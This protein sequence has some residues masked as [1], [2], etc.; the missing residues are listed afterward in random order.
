[1]RLAICA[2]VMAVIAISTYWLG[3]QQ[4]E[5]PQNVYQA[6]PTDPNLVQWRQNWREAGDSIVTANIVGATG[7]Q[8]YV[9]L[10]YIYSGSHGDEV[11]VCGNVTRNGRGGNWSCS[12]TLIRKGRGFT[13]LRLG[14]STQARATECSDAIVI[15][16][17]DATGATFFKQTVPYRKTWIKGEGGLY[18]KFREY[19]SLCPQPNDI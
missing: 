1:M 2:V 12:P 6:L 19:L 7:N 14:M 11:T 3:R 15:D 16:F 8:L 17:Y 13:T 18:G 10:D 4:G 9:Y 5:L